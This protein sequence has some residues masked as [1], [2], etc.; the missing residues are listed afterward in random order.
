MGGGLSLGPVDMATFQFAI[1]YIIS[2]CLLVFPHLKLFNMS[3][4]LQVLLFLP[5][6]Y[7]A[8]RL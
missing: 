7:L 6:T 5:V 3:L 4:K 8:A 2:M 1:L